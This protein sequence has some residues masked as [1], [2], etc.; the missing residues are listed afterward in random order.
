MAEKY[1][2]E[3]G[4]DLAVSDHA[5]DL[6]QRLLPVNQAS[7][8][9]TARAMSLHPRVLQ[10]RLAEA[11][12]SYEEILDDIR[13]ELAWELSATGMQISRIAGALGYSEQSS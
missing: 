13:R 8:V 2:G 6:T 7:L 5:R 12:M 3:I 9:E 1:L 11:G 4:P 10:R